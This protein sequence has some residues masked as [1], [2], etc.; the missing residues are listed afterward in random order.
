MNDS[1]SNENIFDSAIWK[2]DSQDDN[3]ESLV[4]NKNDVNNKSKNQNSNKTKKSK[5]NSM[6]SNSNSNNNNNSMNNNSDN[7]NNSSS[8]G[9][10]VPNK[11]KII[12]N[13]NNNTTQKKLIL[14]VNSIPYSLKM[15]RDINKNKTLTN[16][17]PLQNIISYSIKA[18]EQNVNL[19]ERIKE[20]VI[21]D[22]KTE[23]KNK[24]NLNNEQKKTN[25]MNFIKNQKN[26]KENNAMHV[27]NNNALNNA[28]KI[29]TKEKNNFD[30]IKDNSNSNDEYEEDEEFEDEN[31]NE[32]LQINKVASIDVKSNNMNMNN[33]YYPTNSP[34]FMNSNNSKN[35]NSNKSFSNQKC[36]SEDSY[37]KSL[38]FD[39]PSGRSNNSNKTFLTAHSYQG[40]RTEGNY[41]YSNMFQFPNAINNQNNN[42]LNNN[43]I[44]RGKN[45]GLMGSFISTGATSYS[46]SGIRYDTSNSNESGQSPN[47]YSA[48]QRQY[49]NTNINN[50]GQQN[51]TNNY[52]IGANP[53][54]SKFNSNELVFK[55]PFILN[56]SF[57][58]N[59]NNLFLSNR[60]PK[61]K[62]IINL[63][64]IA[65]GIEKRTTVM[66]R[67]V[68]I[69]YSTEV[70]EKEL[71]CFNG[72][73]DCIYLP[74]DYENKGN[75]GYGFINLI[76]PY[77]VLLFY[78][79]FQGKCWSFFESKKICEL[80]FANFQGIEEIKK[81]AKNYKGKKPK[82]YSVANSLYNNSIEIPKKYLGLISKI[83][84]YINFEV[85]QNNNLE[86][87]GLTKYK[88]INFSNKEKI[89]E[90]NAIQEK[91]EEF[92]YSNYFNFT[93]K[94]KNSEKYLNY[95]N[96][97]IEII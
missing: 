8:N 62:Q 93:V 21:K 6:N 40:N 70:L 3:E 23:N 2:K 83:I 55:Q 13:G 11:H 39:P 95:N 72:K 22:R 31:D 25:K 42:N 32:V 77:H 7:N 89:F 37:F 12:N 52:S 60:E 49:S 61:E 35:S 84:E 45:P 97:N 48:R 56:T 76:K 92:S 15:K 47:N 19:L 90:F 88:L 1:P 78:E 53:L 50:I 94:I 86:W 68:P 28:N 54:A 82:F 85:N 51:Q 65:K 17:K 4:S 18:K 5:S 20:K 38:L 41:P 64:N 80:N 27:N 66:I 16:K 71:E 87:I 36:E 24:I 34:Y 69:K 73:F 58:Y 26:K 81:H 9:K 75:K 43:I 30:K 33:Q 46:Q 96:L 44:V 59:K 91:S 29:V 79:I 14:P 57:Y 10:N 74:F 63:E 67:N